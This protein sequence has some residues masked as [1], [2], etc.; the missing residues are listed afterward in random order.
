MNRHARSALYGTHY[1]INS[2]LF[3]CNLTGSRSTSLQLI[4]CAI[5]VNIPP[6][7]D[8]ESLVEEF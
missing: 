8:V 7:V 3:S 2:I 4:L 1:V 6:K 5:A